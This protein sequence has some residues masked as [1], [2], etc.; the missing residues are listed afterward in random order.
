MTNEELSSQLDEL[1]AELEKAKT[2]SP[3]ERDLFG[4][5]MLDMVRIAQGEEPAIKPKET[6]RDQLEHKA[7]DFESGHPRLAA[8]IR[9]VL[10]A[11]NKM[12]I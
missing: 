7:S 12:G 5:L 6:L 1:H 11:L 4:H 9:Q 3:G 2:L 8:V 10:D